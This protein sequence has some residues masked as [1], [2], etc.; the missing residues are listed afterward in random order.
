MGRPRVTIVMPN[1][2]G[3]EL[4]AVA[5]PSVMAQEA[6]DF[7][8]VV[9]D[10]ASTDDSVAYLR[11]EW[12]DARVVELGANVGFASA[13]NAGIR[14]AAGEYVALLNTDVELEPAW[15]ATLVGA[16]DG[17]PAV[18][19]ACGK[20]LNFYE[21]ELIDAA[22]DVLMRSGTALSRGAGRLDDGRYDQPELVFAPCAGAAVYRRSLFETVGLFDEDFHSYW[23][24][25][26]LGFRAQLAG[27]RSLY[28][29]Q[30]RAYHVR[31]ATTGR[32]NPFFLRLQRRNQ[33]W[34]ITKNFPASLL[35]RN[36][37]V[38]FLRQV[39]YFGA[40][41]QQRLV[42]AHLRAVAEAVRGLPSMLRK[43]REI[44]RGR[45]V[46][47]RYL[48]GIISPRDGAS[49]VRR[50]VTEVA[51]DRVTERPERW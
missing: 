27:F 38:I 20:L 23:E 45:A 1:F 17:D 41:V 10:D 3:R 39:A 49:R 26:D 36:L 48:R 44:Q 33:L 43:R 7:E 29:P 40:S 42:L 22:G 24:D 11:R 47:D 30:A 51:P 16:L 5:L 12:P 28:V 46:D 2:N 15:L 25:V 14:E 9:V 50:V 21:R 13:C 35:L 37:P 4:L 18:G 34:T 6:A 19:S 32:Q 8:L 31:S